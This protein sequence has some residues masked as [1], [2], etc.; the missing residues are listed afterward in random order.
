MAGDVR[1]GCSGWN[2][3]HWRDVV[4]PPRTPPA[5]WLA[6]YARLF[7]T[8][9][10]NATF[11]RLPTRRACESWAEGTPAGFLFAVKVSRYLTH[12]RRLQ[13]VAEGMEVL[14]ERIE[15]LR[16]AGKLGPLLWQLPE[17]F[18]RD[19]ERLA[20]ALA[21]M[22]AG[23][24]HCV[25]FRHASWFDPAVLALLRRHGV[26][27]V[28]GDHPGRPFQTLEVTAPFTFVRFHHGAPEGGGAYSPAELEPW[29]ER[30]AAWRREIDVYAYFNND[31]PSGDPPYPGAVRDALELMR[32]A[33]LPAP[34]APAY[35]A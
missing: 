3:R 30:I 5:R 8:V 16:E 35:R 6:H 4:Y 2:Y 23:V 29:A 9:E 10:V 24:R 19:D 33:G 32:M 14:F 11:Y 21:A 13:G 26:A 28:V 1:I 12:V 31:W 27:L 7:D 15:P 22:P 18:R 34:P 20:S 25:E 17:S